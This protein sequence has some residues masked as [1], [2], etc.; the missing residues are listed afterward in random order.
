VRVAFQ[1]TD[2]DEAV[3]VVYHVDD[4]P[5]LG[6]AAQ[7]LPN[8]IDGTAER[9]DRDEFE[10]VWHARVDAVLTDDDLFSVGSTTP[11]VD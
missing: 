7:F 4:V 9:A 1:R 10:R 2:T 5:P 6:S 3:E 11:F 8:I